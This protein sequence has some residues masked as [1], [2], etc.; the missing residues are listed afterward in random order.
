MVALVSPAVTVGGSG[1][2]R[3]TI[4]GLGD[5]RMNNDE[6]NERAEARELDEAERMKRATIVVLERDFNLT[7]QVFLLYYSM[8]AY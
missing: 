6:D 7:S 8:L 5:R 2:G 3:S 1:G 4:Q